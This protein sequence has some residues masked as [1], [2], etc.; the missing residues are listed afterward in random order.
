[1]PISPQ[2]AIAELQHLRMQAETDE[3]QQDGPEHVK[4][5]HSVDAVMA[6]SVPATSTTLQE[7]RNLRCNIGKYSGAPGEAERDR[8]YFASQ[9]RRA[10]API[11]AT[12]EPST[13]NSGSVEPFEPGATVGRNEARLG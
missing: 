7:F 3:V 12:L 9:V 11:D 2:Q 4:W 5:R 13:V 1:M 8:Q 6:N 10:A